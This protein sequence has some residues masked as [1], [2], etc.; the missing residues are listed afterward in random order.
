MLGD[1]LVARVEF[2]YVRLFAE[3]RYDAL[4]LGIARG[5]DV[6]DVV[7]TTTGGDWLLVTTPFATGWIDGA[8][9]RLFASR[10]Q[11]EGER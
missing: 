11:A 7:T 2:A 5:G 9:A 4:I 6:L 1:A 3:P 8:D 10:R